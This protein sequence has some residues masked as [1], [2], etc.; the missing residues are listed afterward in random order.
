MHN[1]VYRRPK[2]FHPQSLIKPIPQLDD[3][4]TTTDQSL[5]HVLMRLER[6]N[7]HFQLRPQPEIS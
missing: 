1:D 2:N 7:I 4:A 3:Y 6:H 5:Y